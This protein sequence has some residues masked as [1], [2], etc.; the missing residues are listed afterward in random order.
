MAVIHSPESRYAQERSKWE[1]RYTHD[2]I[3][4]GKPEYGTP[5]NPFQHFP[6]ALYR[7]GRP[8]AG[9]VQIV[10]YLI[11]ES[12]ADLAV[13]LS[14]GWHP[15]QEQ[16]IQAVH[17]DEQQKARIAAARNYEDRNMSEKARSEAS[18]YEAQT[19]EHVAEVPTAQA[20]R[21]EAEG[22]RGR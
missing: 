18:A 17:I 8:N 9:P 5:G 14:N 13:K 4:A 6:K 19:S 3:P 7:A 12:E 2:G 10:G 1:T 16:A 21:H 20:R 11:A 22:K 15:S